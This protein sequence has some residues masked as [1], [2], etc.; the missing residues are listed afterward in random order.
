MSDWNPALYSRY[1]DER[2]RPAQELLAR[3]P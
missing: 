1:E 3:V 2:T